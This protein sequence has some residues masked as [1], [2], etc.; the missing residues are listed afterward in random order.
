[1]RHLSHH[2]WMRSEQ[3]PFGRFP[4]LFHPCV[5]IS[6]PSPLPLWNSHPLVE[7]VFHLMQLLEEVLLM[8]MPA[9]RVRKSQRSAERA[10]LVG[11][12]GWRGSS[13]NAAVSAYLAL[14]AHECQ[15]V[16]R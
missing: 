11:V 5:L 8:K 9:M 12:G 1:M 7:E 2:V 16:Q 14:F 15:K 6:P 13:E 3:Q 4:T 10:A